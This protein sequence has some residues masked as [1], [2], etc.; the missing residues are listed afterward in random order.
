MES[1]TDIELGDNGGA[2]ARL[3]QAGVYHL[4]LV[5]RFLL[6]RITSDS[7]VGGFVLLGW[8]NRR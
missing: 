6:E 4:T 2:T 7:E 8:Q 5:F 1:D 3:P